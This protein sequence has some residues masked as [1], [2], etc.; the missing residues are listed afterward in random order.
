MPPPQEQTKFITA[1]TQPQTFPP[2]IIWAHQPDNNQAELADLEILPPVSWQPEFVTR[3]AA[4]SQPGKHPLH[5]AGYF[6]CL[7]FSS[8]F[9]A[10]ALL[11]INQPI[12]LAIDMCAAP[13]GKSVFAWRSLQPN[14]LISNEIIGKRIGILISNLKRCQIQPTHV[15]SSDSEKFA[16]L[17]PATADVVFVDAPCSGQSLLAKG[18]QAPGCFH[19]VTINK[20]ANRQKRI[21]ANSAQVVAPQGYL[22][23]MTCAYS[24]A[25]NEQVCDWFLQR[26]PQFQPLSVPHL[27]A[28]QF[29]LTS[30]PC[31]QLFSQEKL[32]A[33]GFVALFR[34]TENW[35]E[36]GNTAGVL[37]AS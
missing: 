35:Q 21:L 27:A 9:T 24:I 4:K 18:M 34:N 8:V 20:N 5:E 12:D 32:A 26:F 30:M 36:R 6:Y 1:L 19:P 7:D 31:Y 10:S 29:Y 17:I 11:A 16:H 2:T 13:G 33:G 3:L 15:T 14:C 23:Y 25:E 28:Y 37:A 22:V